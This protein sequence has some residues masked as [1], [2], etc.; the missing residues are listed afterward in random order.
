MSE[1][2]GASRESLMPS[3]AYVRSRP[4]RAPAE[5]VARRAARRSC[6]ASRYL[7]AF[8]RS[9][10]RSTVGGSSSCAVA[11]DVASGRTSSAKSANGAADLR[12][13]ST[14][15]PAEV[16][17]D[18][19]TLVRRECA[20]L[21]PRRRPVSQRRLAVDLGAWRERLRP[22][23]GLRLAFAVVLALLLLE[24]PARVEQAT[25]QLLLPRE[26]PRIE[27]PTVERVRE[28]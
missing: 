10:A 19:A 7:P 9:S 2:R 11:R 8:S 5:G 6:A 15:Q 25:E 27:T 24:W 12:R 18:G 16:V 13:R 21:V 1:S 26:R 22:R 23:R 3:S 17:E 4:R 14:V 28:L 20:Q